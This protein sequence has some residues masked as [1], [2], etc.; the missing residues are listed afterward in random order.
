VSRQEESYAAKL[1]AAMRQQ[2]G[3]HVVQRIQPPEEYPEERD[4]LRLRNEQRKGE[5]RPGLGE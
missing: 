1:L 2:F 4:P 3:G 5:E